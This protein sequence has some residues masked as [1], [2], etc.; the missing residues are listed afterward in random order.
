MG[1]TNKGKEKALRKQS[2]RAREK[3]QVKARELAEMMKNPKYR[4]QREI[5]TTKRYIESCKYDA[6]HNKYINAIARLKKYN[7]ILGF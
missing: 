6:E 3:N 4:L 5:N 1:N 7:N 2:I